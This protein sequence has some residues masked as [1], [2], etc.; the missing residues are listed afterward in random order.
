MQSTLR[1]SGEPQTRT[2]RGTAKD[3]LREM[4]VEKIGT[5]VLR[6]LKNCHLS[7]R[8]RCMYKTERVRSAP[9]PTCEPGLFPKV[10]LPVPILGDWWYICS[11]IFLLTVRHRRPS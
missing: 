4:V 11:L 1:G 3:R 10:G 7:V 2:G 6:L 9:L 8:G 5:S